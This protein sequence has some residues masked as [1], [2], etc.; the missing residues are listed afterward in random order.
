MMHLID[1]LRTRVQI[2]FHQIIKTNTTSNHDQDVKNLWNKN[3]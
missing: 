2:S 1:T 3:I